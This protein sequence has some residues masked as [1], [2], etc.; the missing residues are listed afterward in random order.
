MQPWM[1]VLPYLFLAVIAM[2][3]GY[4]CRPTEAER[5]RWR[6]SRSDRRAEAEREGYTGK[7]C[8]RCGSRD[9]HTV[10]TKHAMG[11]PRTELVC[12][13]CGYNWN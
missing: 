5:A 3:G 12:R 11:L 4:L 6:V 8:D 13:E 1:I 10:R 9:L 2:L 7:L